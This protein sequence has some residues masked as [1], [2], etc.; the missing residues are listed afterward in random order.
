MVGYS[1]DPWVG[2][3]GD[4]FSEGDGGVRAGFGGVGGLSEAGC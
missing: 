2:G 3:V 4:D 1:S